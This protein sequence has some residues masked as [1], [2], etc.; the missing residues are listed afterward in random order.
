MSKPTIIDMGDY[1]GVRFEIQAGN[2]RSD[3]LGMTLNATVDK[4]STE[5]YMAFKKLVDKNN[6]QH[7]EKRLRVYYHIISNCAVVKIYG[8]MG[9]AENK[10]TIG[11]LF[12][13]TFT[14]YGN[15]IEFLSGEHAIRKYLI[16]QALA[17]ADSSPT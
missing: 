1:P 14:I 16:D 13:Y 3:K 2:T 17:D 6:S 12:E 5:M 11:H 10:N 15:D 7:N 8:Y 9:R 4:I